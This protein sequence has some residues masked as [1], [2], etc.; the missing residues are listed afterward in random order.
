MTLDALSC[1]TRRAVAGEVVETR[2]EHTL[3]CHNH[4]GG[5]SA[6]NQFRCLH[7]ASEMFGS[8]KEQLVD[9]QSI[10]RGLGY[11]WRRGGRS[12]KNG[13][14][15]DYNHNLDLIHALA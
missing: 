4:N 3:T 13:S 8:T 1:A 7:T 12:A 2:T 15:W 14:A 6:K 11:R 5:K 10:A 9:A